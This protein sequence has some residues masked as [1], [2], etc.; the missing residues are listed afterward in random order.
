MTRR[1][2]ILLDAF[3][4][5]SR[6]A[7]VAGAVEGLVAGLAA[8]DRGFDFILAVGDP[9]PWAWLARR[10]DW[11]VVPLAGVAAGGWRK[12]WATQVKLP[13]LCRQTGADLVHVPQFIAPLS[14]PCPLVLTVND[15]AWQVV[16]HTVEWSRRF[17]YRWLVPAGLSAAAA[18][19]AISESTAAD[20]RRY[21]PAH[22]EK[23]TVVPLATPE[24][25]WQVAAQLGTESDQEGRPYFLFVGTQ[26]PRKNLAGLVEAYRRFLAQARTEGRDAALIPDLVLAGG[27]GWLAGDILERA[28]SELGERLRV[29]GYVS[30][31]ELGVLYRHAVALVFPSLLEGFGL[32]ILEAMALGVPVLTGRSGA[33]AEI[34]GGRALLVDPTDT[35][36]LAQALHKLTWNDERRQELGRNG[37]EHARSYSWERTAD[38]TVSIYDRVLSSP[39]AK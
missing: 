4:V 37:P 29:P 24:W 31:V 5:R 21:F 34:S 32:P 25:V 8:R 27:E 15:L 6:T 12:A 39:R 35:A 13:H 17:F 36:E 18:V 19:V 30:R 16:P 38:L 14:C 1:P 22:A 11:S 23:V 28:K 7:G 9:S 20:V 3:A 2:R 33:T 10:S 26:E